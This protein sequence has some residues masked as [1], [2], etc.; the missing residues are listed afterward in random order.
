[1]ETFEASFGAMA[2]PRASNVRHPLSE[3]LFIAL[4]AT[5]CGAQS[6]VDMALFARAKADF[7]RESVAMAHGPPSHDTFSRV[8]RQLD[9]EA[10]E[11]AFAAFT[12]AFAGALEGVVAIDGK[13]LKGAYERGARHSPL[14]LVNV[15]AAEARFA[16]A[17][18]LAPGRNEVRG[19]LDAL[20]LL[21]LKD[22]IVTA[23]ALHCRPDV[24]RAIREAGGDYALRVKANQPRLL[25][26]AERRLGGEPQSADADVSVSAVEERHDRAEVRRARVIPADDLEHSFGFA[27]A[28]ALA[29]LDAVRQTADGEETVSTRY[30][31]LSA[32]LRAGR[33]AHVARAHWSIENH[34]HWTLDVA[35]NEDAARNRAGHG[36]QNLALLRKIALNI[37]RADPDKGSIK[38]K[39]KRAGWDNAFLKQLLTHMR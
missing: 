25:A 17:Q 8:F 33:L 30:F 31:I 36:A 26:E 15:W 28:C 2:D 39:I 6:C 7:L 29:R 9:P 37:I 5:L 12:R 20:A 35:F 3:V 11:A 27:G 10:F 23:D 21:D 4:A 13:A 1:M 18:R 38:G 22:C 19:A 32:S 14:H 24:A 16:V 34:L